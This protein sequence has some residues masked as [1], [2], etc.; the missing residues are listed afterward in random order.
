MFEFYPRITMKELT[1]L[2]DDAIKEMLVIDIE[3]NDN[4][5][6]CDLEPLLLMHDN[7]VLRCTHNTEIDLNKATGI[8]IFGTDN[9]IKSNY[10]IENK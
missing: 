4:T 7:K 6:L 1:K 3:L 10:K 2:L 8:R 5:V 9:K